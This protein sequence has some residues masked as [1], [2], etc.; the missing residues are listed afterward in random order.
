VILRR[1]ISQEGCCSEIAACV[2]FGLWMTEVSSGRCPR[3]GESKRGAIDR[4]AKS[5]ARSRDPQPY[6]IM[7]SRCI[8]NLRPTHDMSLLAQNFVTVNW[9]F[10]TF[11]ENTSFT[12]V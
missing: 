12:F 2:W 4:C 1:A 11:V 6:S 9:L 7:H 3:A 10:H 5:L 8:V